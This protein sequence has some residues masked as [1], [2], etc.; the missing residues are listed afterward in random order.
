MFDGTDGSAAISTNSLLNITKPTQMGLLMQVAT[1]AAG[2][3]AAIASNSASL[4]KVCVGY[5]TTRTTQL[6]H[7]FLVSLQ[8]LPALS[9]MRAKLGQS[10]WD[11]PWVQASTS[12]AG[13]LLA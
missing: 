9:L 8:V 10:F 5:H 6:N 4:H 3:N 11:R 2:S 7:S 12:L 1:T 13:R